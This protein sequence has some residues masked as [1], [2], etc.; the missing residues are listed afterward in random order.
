MPRLGNGLQ[1]RQGM[2]A[3]WK[4]K[5]DALRGG[6]IGA[7]IGLLPGLGGAVADWMAYSSNSCKPSKINLAM[8]IS[9]E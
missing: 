3:V 6:I 2:I 9:K 1:T 7:F 5:W 8:V 4:N